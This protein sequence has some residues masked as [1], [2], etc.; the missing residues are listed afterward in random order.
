MMSN[1]D[2]VMMILGLEDEAHEQLIDGESMVEK[3]CVRSQLTSV[4]EPRKF[5]RRGTQRM[6]T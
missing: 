5:R 1:H 3:C 2:D 6:S 4:K